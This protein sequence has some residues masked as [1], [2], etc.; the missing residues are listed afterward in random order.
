MSEFK[1][2]PSPRG[3][4]VALDGVPIGVVWKNERYYNLR[5]PIVERGWSARTAEG[6]TL[7]RGESTIFR[8]RVEAAQALE[9]R[10]SS[11]EETDG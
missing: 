6:A 2:K 10:R 5:R 3:Y 1:F 8:T 7:G 11:G 4:D 9:A